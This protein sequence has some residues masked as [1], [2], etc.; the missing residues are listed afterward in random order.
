MNNDEFKEVPQGTEDNDINMSEN[1]T[2]ITPDM[3]GNDMP[4]PGMPTPDNPD[5]GHDNDEKSDFFFIKYVSL[6]WLNLLN[7]PAEVSPLRVHCLCYARV[8]KLKS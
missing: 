4:E 2:I 5:P 8:V 3:P 6:L 1:D 7:S